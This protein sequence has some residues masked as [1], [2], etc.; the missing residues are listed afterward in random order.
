MTNRGIDITG[1][2]DRF[3]FTR[4]SPRQCEQLHAASLTILERTGVRLYEPEALE[5]VKRAGAEVSDGNRVRIPSRLV[6]QALQTAPKRVVLYDRN[7]EPVMPLEHE[8]A[9]E[10]TRRLQEIF[11]Q[12]LDNIAAAEKPLPAECVQA[13]YDLWRNEIASDPL[14]W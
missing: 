8:S 12:A 1:R 3:A 6:E 5:L 10:F 7:G 14:P 9:H 11:E 13:I 4:L 2:Q